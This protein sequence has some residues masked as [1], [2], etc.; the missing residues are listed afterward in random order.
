MIKNRDYYEKEATLEEWKEWY[1]QQEAPSYIHPDVATDAIIVHFNKETNKLEI[2]LQKREIHPYRGTQTLP[3][4][5][6]H[7]DEK[8][9]E[10]SLRRMF[11]TKLNSYIPHN[12]VIDQLA[13]YSNKDR[14]PRGQVISVVHM[15]Y[16]PIRIEETE[17]LKWYSVEDIQSGLIPFGFDHKE[18]IQDGISR[19]QDQ[20]PWI[21]YTIF[22][23]EAPFTL[24]NLVHLKAQ[25]MGINPK[26]INRA[27]YRKQM[28][29]FI[30]KDKVIDNITYYN[31]RKMK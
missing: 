30:A 11:E 18:I 22:S 2:L 17:S 16:T 27:N 3:G 4:T 12:A 14:D 6:L 24:G 25:L 28:L 29:R 31:Q 1:E 26:S 7:A 8:D 15:I 23:V 9:I 20:F 19:M 10:E 21:P 13:T 5:F